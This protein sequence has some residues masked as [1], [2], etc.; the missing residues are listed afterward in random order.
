[1]IQKSIETYSNEKKQI[2]KLRNTNYSN[3]TNVISVHINCLIPVYIHIFFVKRGLPV[4]PLSF[5]FLFF[6]YFRFWRSTWT[7]AHFFPF[8]F[9]RT[10]T[11][12][13]KKNWNNICTKERNTIFRDGC[14]LLLIWLRFAKPNI[15]TFSTRETE[16]A[17][18]NEA[19][20]LS[21]IQYT[22]MKWI[23][24]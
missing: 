5:S 18:R 23:V 22:R 21:G 24:L 6:L 20:V 14:I 13:K 2:L 11:K 12:K 3:W 19:L 8:L 9:F 17:E 7:C 1:M 16:R 10:M 15:Y 4:K